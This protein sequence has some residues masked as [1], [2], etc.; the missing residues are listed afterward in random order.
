MR[1]RRDRNARADLGEIRGCIAKDTPIRAR[2]FV[3]ELRARAE[4][5]SEYPRRG[6]IAYD[7]PLGPVH[8]LV[9]G[10]YAIY[11]RVLETE[12]RVIGVRHGRRSFASRPT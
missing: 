9:H 7:T 2:T 12:V 8:K 4:A 6:E 1:V 3:A 11:Y 5:L 10:Q